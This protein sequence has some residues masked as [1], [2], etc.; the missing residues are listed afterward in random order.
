[1]GKI[2]VVYYSL[3]GSCALIANSIAEAAGAEI[4]RIE[5][6]KPMSGGKKSKLFFGGMQVIFK[7]RPAIKPLDI[8]FDDYEL[9]IIGTP[10]WVSTF[11]PAVRTF[12]SENRIKNRKIALFCCYG[13]D[14][15]KTFDNMKAKL[16]DNECIGSIGFKQPIEFETEKAVENAKKW[17]LDLMKF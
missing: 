10:V 15:G 8:N 7:M 1:M 4:K 11:A 5:C 2:L 12:L 9:I 6:I 14:E 3:D 17:V 16:H 13:G